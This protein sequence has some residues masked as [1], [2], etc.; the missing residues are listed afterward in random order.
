[1]RAAL[2]RHERVDLVDDH[3]LDR[4]EDRSRLRGEQ[5]VERLR[6][7]D[8]NVRRRAGDAGA[9]ARRGVAR[10][11]RD[12]RDTEGYAGLLGD[13]RDAGER[14]AQVALDVGGERFERGNIEDPAPFALV[15]LGREHHP[16]DAGEE[17]RQRL[18]RAGRR[19][20]QRRRAR[21]DRRPALGL[22]GRRRGE[23]GLEP[24]AHRRVKVKAR[25]RAGDRDR[26]LLRRHG[27]II[28]E[29]L[30]P[31]RPRALGRCVGG[32]RR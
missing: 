31:A 6:R 15:R 4:R 8:E 10:A 21:E 32:A 1:M 16:I 2:G 18:A 7:G 11:D 25:E 13:L 30:R 20:E 23:R 5:E 14:P 9:L 27:P 19:E 12:A 3:R 24:G 28:V 26:G 17:R 22:R 29:R